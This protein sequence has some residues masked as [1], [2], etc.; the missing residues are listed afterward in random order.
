[1]DKGSSSFVT[2][3]DSAEGLSGN[4]SLFSSDCSSFTA[5]SEGGGGVVSTPEVSS[6]SGSDAVSKF[7]M[8]GPGWVNGSVRPFKGWSRPSLDDTSSFRSGTETCLAPTA[9]TGSLTATLPPFAA[10]P[11]TKSM[12]D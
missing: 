7:S 9:N 3:T 2:S 10:I 1:V 5:G 4:V 8:I 12:M 11:L 6:R